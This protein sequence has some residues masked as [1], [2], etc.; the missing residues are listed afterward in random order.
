MNQAQE[1]QL[2]ITL[3]L[4]AIALIM[5]GLAQLPLGR[6]KGLFEAL[7][8][9]VKKALSPPEPKEETPAP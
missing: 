7:E 8:T 9:E 4:S 2:T 3:S 6:S 1:P 5:D